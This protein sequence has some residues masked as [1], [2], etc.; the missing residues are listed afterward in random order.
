MRKTNDTSKVA[1]LR[2]LA[3]SELDGVTGGTAQSVTNTTVVAR[4][5]PVY[6]TLAK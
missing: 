4:P 5:Q 3:D 6:P 2:P 1:A